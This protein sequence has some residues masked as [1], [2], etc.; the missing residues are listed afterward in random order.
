MLKLI[1]AAV[2]GILCIS[3]HSHAFANDAELIGYTL[4]DIKTIEDDFEGCDFDKVIKFLDG[5][6]LVC[7]S[8]SYTYDFMPEAKIYRRRIKFKEKDYMS[9]KMVVDDDV[10]DM[11]PILISKN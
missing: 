10:Y 1:T 6:S 2:G 8:Y 5:T 7:S 3:V 4:I 11:M 9:I